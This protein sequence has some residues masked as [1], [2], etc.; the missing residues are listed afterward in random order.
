MADTPAEDGPVT[1]CAEPTRD[2][3]ELVNGYDPVRDFMDHSPDACM[4]HFTKLQGQRID[5]AFRAVRT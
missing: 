2:T 4:D 5:L 1:S 3:C